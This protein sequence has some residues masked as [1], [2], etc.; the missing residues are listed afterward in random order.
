MGS[1]DSTVF[2]VIVLFAEGPA[3]FEENYPEFSRQ[4]RDAYAIA[5][6]GYE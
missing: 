2:S 6:P 1:I 3:E 4:M 5:H